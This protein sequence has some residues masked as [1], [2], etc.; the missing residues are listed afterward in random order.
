MEKGHYTYISS[1]AEEGY[2]AI[3]INDPLF[4]GGREQSISCP[5]KNVRN[6]STAEEI[7]M[8]DAVITEFAGTRKGPVARYY[9]YGRNGVEVLDAGKNVQRLYLFG[10]GADMMTERDIAG[11]ER[12]LRRFIF[13]RNGMLEE[14]FSF[15]RPP[16]TFRYENGGRLIAVREGGQYGAVSKTFTFDRNGI[17]ET[18]WGREGEVE[19]VYIFEPGNDMITERIGGWYGPVSRTI[20]FE[21]ID[22]S[23]FRD[24]E[25]FLQFMV[26]TE[27]SEREADAAQTIGAADRVQGAGAPP[28][29]SR[30]AFTG[31]R[32]T[33]SDTV[34]DTGTK[35][36]DIRIDFIPD[37][38]APVEEPPSEKSRPKK[39][40]E[41]SYEERRSGR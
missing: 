24:P 7:Q 21:G 41:I 39:S 27:R 31:Q 15:G 26:F 37:G 38:D 35:E 18:A 33:P 22:A 34:P 40:S 10:P 1:L 13:D 20:V 17:I 4:R 23:V 8:A 12:I 19:R 29:R 9:Q 11:K 6:Q 28:A 2:P 16:R 25:S 30:F 5:G 36:D 3:S 32:R 14:T